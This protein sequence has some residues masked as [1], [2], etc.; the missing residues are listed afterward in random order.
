MRNLSG[1][2]ALVTGAARGMGRV[3]LEALGREGC[4]LIAVDVDSER[5]G[6]RRPEHLSAR[7]METHTLHPRRLGP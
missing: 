7:G 4:R 5:A 3:H 2:L 1:K 6:A